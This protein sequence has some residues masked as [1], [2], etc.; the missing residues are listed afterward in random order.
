MC[1]QI[2]KHQFFNNIQIHKMKI[3]ELSNLGAYEPIWFS[4]DYRL[5]RP[6]AWH[7]CST[8]RSQQINQSKRSTAAL[9]SKLLSYVEK[10]NL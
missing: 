4:L 2:A 7:G 6:P 9:I 8:Y 1:F 3:L 5:Q 10:R